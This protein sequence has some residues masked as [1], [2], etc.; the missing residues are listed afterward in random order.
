MGGAVAAVLLFGL[1]VAQGLGLGRGVAALGVCGSSITGQLA[2]DI[3]AAYAAQSR[4]AGNRF[5]FRNSDCDVRFATSL[6]VVTLGHGMLRSPMPGLSIRSARNV[7]GHDGIVAI[8][9]PQNS[10]S[11]LSFDQLSSILRGM[12]ANWAVVHGANAPISVY[13]PADNTDEARV[14]ET[15]VLRGAALGSHVVRVPTSADVV[16]AVTAAN[17]ANRIGIVAF[18]KSVPAKVVAIQPFAVPSTISISD[19]AYP[20]ALGVTV[21]A[22]GES[23]DPTVA[24]LLAFATTHNGKSLA[25]HDGFAP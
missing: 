6:N 23:H 17:G 20:F 16:R 5:E 4:V 1:F 14:A 3:V 19:G 9:N 12:T 7:L 15:E 25:M 10:V 11:S 2:Q 21:S 13:V 8:V 22:G 24:D 18:S